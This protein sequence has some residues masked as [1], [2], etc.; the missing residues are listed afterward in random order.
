MDTGSEWRI[1]DLHIH[2][3]ESFHHVFKFVDQ[4]DR[5][6]YDEDLWK[7]YIDELEN[8]SNVSVLG[9]TDY[10]G[11]EGYK[12]VL[13]YKNSEKLKNFDLI[14]PNIE[15]R[16]D[17][18]VGDKRLNFHIIFSEQIGINQIEK[19]FLEELHIQAPNAE[20]R[21]LT[22][23][24]IQE[25]GSTLKEQHEGFRKKP[26]FVIGCENITV[27]LTQI[28]D[29]LKNRAS[30][31]DGKYMLV[32]PEDGWSIID[33]DSQ[34]HLTRKTILVQSHAVFSSNS[35]TRDWLLGGKYDS[36]EDFVKEFGSLKP[37]IHSSDSHS[38]ERLCKPDLDR[39]CWI[40]AETTFEGLKQILYEPEA[41]VRIQPENPEYR[42]NI[43]TLKSV[44]IRNS[45]ISD[46]L[47]I[48]E[49]LISINCNLVAVVG[50][51][52]SGK[53]ALLD[54]IAN[55]FEDRCKR[56]GV[57]KNS[58]VQRIEDQ[59]S[60]LEVEISFLGAGIS[61]LSKKITDDDFFQDSVITYLPQGKIEEYSGDRIKLDKKIQEIIFNNKDILE[62]GYQKEFERISNEI[63]QFAKKIDE[64]N[65]HI[66]G[67]E[68]ETKE[69][70]IQDV[71][72][73][74]AKS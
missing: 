10:F 65:K 37:C 2:T 59:K 30:I 17:T 51:K 33:W 64:I 66:N 47:S 26:D 74:K 8:I 29:I 20:P 4:E 22:K 70:I 15:F 61:N 41:R 1:W 7:K 40:K 57:D 48:Q 55:S 46:E 45:S 49:R 58:F 11:I 25:I 13:E 67:L 5:N 54:L 27:S 56:S 31:F 73:K 34:D 35:N 18:F 44:E 16:L 24:N 39:F 32:L 19:D 72:N 21:K 53:T 42:K 23:E 60:D 38:F 9:V 71:E 3:P 12:K 52:G 43:Y 36:P 63:Q 62:G 69:E 28:I 68:E 6:K 14:L 50:G